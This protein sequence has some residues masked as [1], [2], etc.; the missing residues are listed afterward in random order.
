MSLRVVAVA[1]AGLA[2]LVLAAAWLFE[3]SLERAALL[4]PVI[5]VSFAAVAGLVVLWTR[6]AL[7]SL[8]EARHPRLIV[9]IA[10]GGVAV[11]AFLTWLGIELPRD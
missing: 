8:R 11:L 5:V 2:A 10:L 4:A 1:V 7:E 3:L 6:V 9:G